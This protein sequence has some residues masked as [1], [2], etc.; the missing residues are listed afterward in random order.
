VCKTIL[1][2]TD[3]SAHARKAVEVASDL[4][5]KYGA[6]LVL[7]HVLQQQKVPAT[8]R[9]ALEVEHLAQ[10]AE[11]RPLPSTDLSAIAVAASDEVSASQAALR[12][13]ADAWGQQVLEEAE[14]AARAKGVTSIRVVM[15]E[16]D[17]VACVVECAQR[18]RAD[19]IVVGSRGLSDLKG[20]LMGNVSHKLSQLAPCTCITVK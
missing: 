13:L 12:Q 7:V 6:K 16:G 17:P 4:A 14:G 3:G 20:L 1:A 15:D 8:V 18:E 9:R 5:A 10:P 11:S 2:A 19:L